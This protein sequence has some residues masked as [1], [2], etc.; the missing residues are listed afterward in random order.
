[1]LFFAWA[2][3]ALF[4]GVIVIVVIVQA[5]VAV[6]ERRRLRDAARLPRRRRGFRPV[7]IEGGKQNAP[8]AERAATDKLAG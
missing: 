5:A 2:P 3:A 8:P 1:M 6:A 7:V 4:S